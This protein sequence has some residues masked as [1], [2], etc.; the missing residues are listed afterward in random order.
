MK[1]QVVQAEKAKALYDSLWSEREQG[2]FRTPTFQQVQLLREFGYL[3]ETKSTVG[4][5]T[6]EQLA[7][8]GTND[9]MVF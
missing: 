3:S 9:A 6:P 1:N 7:A 5:L 4:L 2:K 8:K